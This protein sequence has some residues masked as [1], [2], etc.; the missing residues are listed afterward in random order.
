[1]EKALLE[2]DMKALKEYSISLA[3][4]C[5]MVG[6]MSAEGSL[7]VTQ[8]MEIENFVPA[9]EQQEQEQVAQQEDDDDIIKVDQKFDTMREIRQAAVEYGRR[10]K[11]A[12]STLRSGARQLV[13]GCKHS[14]SYRGT[15]KAVQTT[16]SASQSQGSD[17]PNSLPAIELE[18]TEDNVRTAET[19]A[20][21][22]GSENTSTPSQQTLDN[23]SSTLA[24]FPAKRTRK[25]VT[26]KIQCPFQI[27]AKPVKGEWIVYKMVTEHNHPMASESILYAQH[28]KLNQETT[29]EIV[30]LMRQNKSNLQIIEELKKKGIRNV[31][32]KD[33][34]NIRQS[35]FNPKNNKVSATGNILFQVE[36]INQQ[37][38][39]EVRTETA[40]VVSNS[41]QGE[42]QQEE[43]LLPS[44]ASSP[45]P[46]TAVET[47][48]QQ[49]QIQQ[50]VVQQTVS[51]TVEA[52]QSA[53]NAL[54]STST[55]AVALPLEAIQA[56]QAIEQR[57]QQE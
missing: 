7:Q 36:Q 14:G 37:Q 1:M 31:V 45:L 39:T 38:N 49:D 4:S 42:G 56:L 11:F 13:L 15:K 46:L 40:A 24:V 34:A 44:Q 55:S 8:P 48:F 30:N 20:V 53:V 22:E 6:V 26:R 5:D 25:K 16:D 19:E 28:R 2:N 43:A 10:H 21:A 57:Q 17:S 3:R 33:I 27:R 50:E 35:Y 41:T 32:K 12:V 18:E 47:A 54:Q 9:E 51:T 23:D 52:I 29:Q